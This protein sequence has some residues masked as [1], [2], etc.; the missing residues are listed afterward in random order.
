MYVHVLKQLGLLGG[1]NPQT[2]TFFKS[3]GKRIPASEHLH[4]LFLQPE[5][6]PLDTHRAGS[7]SSRHYSGHLLRGGLPT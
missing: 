3:Q 1:N 7:L 4:L 5:H 6:S 2:E